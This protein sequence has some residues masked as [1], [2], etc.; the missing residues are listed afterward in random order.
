MARRAISAIRALFQDATRD[1]D[2]VDYPDPLPE[3]DRDGY[4]P[5]QWPGAP[6]QKLPPNCPVVPLGKNGKASY[7]IDTLG[8]LTAVTASE[9]GNKQII[10]LF[11][12][13]PNFPLWAWPRR[14][15]P[16]KGKPSKINGLDGDN[17]VRCLVNACAR[18][19]LFEPAD[20]V[21]GRGGWA[22]GKGRFL[23]HSGDRLWTV[24]R[25]KLAVSRP[26]EL[27]GIFYP[28]RP[29]IMRPWEEPVTEEDS[30]AR[31][32]LGDLRTWTFERPV[33][34]PFL[35][36]GGLG[37]ALLG[38]ALD[39]RP[40]LFVTGGAGAGKTTLQNLIAGVLDDALHSTAD[41][42]AAGIYQRVNQDS[43]P[44]AVDELE[45]DASNVKQR[46]VLDLARIAS[47]G[48][49]LFRGGQDHTG[50]EFRARNVFIFSAI[51]PPP[52]TTA[53]KS[54]IGMINLGK[55]DRTSARPVTIDGDVDGRMVL[56]QLMDAWPAFTQRLDDWR[57]TLHG[58]GF[59][60]RA[61][62]TYGTLLAVAE[63]LVGAEAMEDAGMP[64]T[65]E[66]RLG[67]MVRQWTAAERAEQVDN[68]RDCM[69]VLLSSSIEAIKGGEKPTI[70]G[71][72]EQF[73]DGPNMLDLKVARDRLQL[74]GLT[75][76]LKNN[77][78]LDAGY[79][80]MVPPR[81][82]PLKKL[83]AGTVFG[84]GVWFGALKQAPAD[85]VDKS[86]GN[87]AIV[88]INGD[89]HRCLAIDMQA[90]ERL[91]AEERGEAA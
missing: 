50:V 90:Y 61:Q 58:A 41:T 86:L 56:R 27:D 25:G 59:D 36:L 85:I 62:D 12:L 21:R 45:A 43:L 87:H 77:N 6:S 47:S 8:Q 63:I 70:G 83:F 67:E 3:A 16:K 74:A 60:R 78:D 19:G 34:D 55:L 89:A 26:G 91:A 32:L 66:A 17:A 28:R 44:V 4:Q 23:W 49:L 68:W 69:G 15:E 75:I 30:P 33:L 7:L 53:E 38:G 31:R 11:A 64:V 37:C 20:R 76:K 42:T 5:G 24:D 84:S 22:D 1:L 72:L 88:K 9:W 35:V 71:T 46:R 13:T 54:R 29:A 2:D 48:Q 80:L 52:L 18:R 79:W 10:D 14:S 40:T 82:E 51:N 65:D 81:G 73:G 39:W 57:T